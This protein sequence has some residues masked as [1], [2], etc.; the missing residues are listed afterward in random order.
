MKKRKALDLMRPRMFFAHIVSISY[1]NSLI[2]IVIVDIFIEYRASL[3]V[4]GH[5]KR[6]TNELRLLLF[7]Q[8]VFFIYGNIKFF[9]EPTTM[10]LI[11]ISSIMILIS[12]TILNVKYSVNQKSLTII[13]K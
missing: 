3:S 2:Y 13:Y 8:S 6:I 10:F 9:T 1:R 12:I 5:N 11:K 4:V 7:L